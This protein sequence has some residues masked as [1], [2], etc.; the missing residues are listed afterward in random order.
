MSTLFYIIES[1]KTQK[2]KKLIREFATSRVFIKGDYLN[3]L[4]NC[5]HCKGKDNSIATFGQLAT[6]NAFFFF[7]CSDFFP[8]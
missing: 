4:L 2:G 8:F 5:W 6:R 7:S 1:Q 3:L